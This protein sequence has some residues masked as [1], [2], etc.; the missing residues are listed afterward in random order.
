MKFFISL[1]LAIS[2]LIPTTVP[3][4]TKMADEVVIEFQDWYGIGLEIK[5]KIISKQIT[6]FSH[7]GGASM[8]LYLDSNNRPVIEI[9]AGLY[10][11]NTRLPIISFI[12]N[13]TGIEGLV[14]RAKLIKGFRKG[15]F[16]EIH[17]T[18]TSGRSRTE[19]FTLKGFSR[20][21]RWLTK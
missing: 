2:I 16:V 14:D 18:D 19:T 17:F 4:E 9:T 13:D 1:I 7:A 11:A 10:E 8:V 21:Y 15:K 20:A 3:A 5:G 12:D 6:V